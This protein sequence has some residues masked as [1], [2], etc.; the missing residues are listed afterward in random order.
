METYSS[1]KQ[2]S[3]CQCCSENEEIIIQLHTYVPHLYSFVDLSCCMDKNILQRRD[4]N[5]FQKSG[6]Y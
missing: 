1:M 6:S 3:S 4:I 5:F 2:D